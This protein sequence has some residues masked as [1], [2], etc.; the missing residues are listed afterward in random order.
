MSKIDTDDERLDYVTLSLLR[1]DDDD[2]AGPI[3]HPCV[4][5]GPNCRTQINQLRKVLRTWKPSPGFIT[6]KCAR[7]EAQGF[8]QAGTV[9][10]LRPRPTLP[11]A[12][13]ARSSASSHHDRYDL[14][15]VEQLWNGATATLPKSAVAYFKWRGIPINDMPPGALRFHPRCPWW[16]ERRPCLLARYTDAVSGA[17][18]GIWRRCIDWRAPS[19][20][21]PMDIGPKGG[22]VIRLWPDQQVGKRLVIAEGVET[23][24]TGATIKYRDLLPCPAWATGDAGN[25]RR[26]PAIDSIEQLIIL[27]D[28]D[29]SGTGQRAAEECASRWEAAGR[30]VTRLMPRKGGTDFND[31]VKP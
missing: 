10:L 3:D 23:A 13:L 26:F 31:L 12:F 15:Y 16:R 2:F 7:C 8:A 4:L 14:F 19:G 24:L 25:L 9:D 11:E 30:R 28:N 18:R 29:A 22:C 5:C 17:A 27:V 20:W 1:G 21:K 6:Y